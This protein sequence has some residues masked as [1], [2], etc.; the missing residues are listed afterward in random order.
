MS[1]SPCPAATARRICSPTAASA[2]S[3]RPAASAASSASPA[4]LAA[5][6]E[7]ERG[8]ELAVDHHRP[9][10]LGVGRADRRAVD[11][12]EEGPRVD[13]EPLGE[14]DR[15]RQ[16]LGEAEQPRVEHELEAL[17]RARF[18]Q[19][20]GLRADR[21]EDR[22]DALADVLRSGG[23]H[24]QLALLGRLPG[25]GD[26]RVDERDACLLRAPGQAVGGVEA[27]RAHLG[28]HRAVHRPERLLG[29]RLDGRRVGEHRHH[30][31]GARHRLGDAAGDR[32]AVLRERLGLLA[33]AVPR[34]HLVAG[35]GEVARHRR[36]HDPGAE[37]GDAHQ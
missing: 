16:R 30:H 31:V 8:R 11:R 34:A 26:G 25:P 23:E 33:R 27:D 6:V 19:P 7:R 1:S 29:H 37:D 10:E 3:R 4:S 12:R 21:V 24:D 15:L 14:R 32:D 36:A 13:A 9:L 35:G 18:T 22:V 5:S 17:G 28:E 20:H 2:P